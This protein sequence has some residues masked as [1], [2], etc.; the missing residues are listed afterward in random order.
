MRCKIRNGMFNAVVSCIVYLID[1]RMEKRK[2]RESRSTE[3]GKRSCQILN[4]AAALTVIGLEYA[5]VLYAASLLRAR[6]ILQTRIC[7]N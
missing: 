3:N 4:P 6:V 7:H 5:R 2:E 1:K